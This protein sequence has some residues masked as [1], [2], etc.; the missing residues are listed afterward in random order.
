MLSCVLSL[1]CARISSLQ[2]QEA[3]I[4]KCLE[5]FETI[6]EI[7]HQ[8]NRFQLGLEQL[9]QMYENELVTKKTL[10][11]SARLW[12]TIESKLKREVSTLY[13][14]AYTEK[15]FDKTG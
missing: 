11:N 4:D 8:R 13:D 12:H 1:L 3:Q 10:D 15:C 14:T 5:Y 7:Q 9:M 2:A 6:L